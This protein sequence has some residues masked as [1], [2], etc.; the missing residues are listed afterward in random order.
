MQLEIA[1][2]DCPKCHGAFREVLSKKKI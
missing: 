1:L 2:Y